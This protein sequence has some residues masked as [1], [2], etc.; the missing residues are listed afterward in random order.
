MPSC[1]YPR[2]LDGLG[3]VFP[4]ILP[5][6]CTLR[7]LERTKLSTFNDEIF[8]HQECECYVLPPTVHNIY[9][10]ARRHSRAQGMDS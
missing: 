4:K 5:M 10:L 7:A 8:V 9:G 1:L 3:N 6:G 2:A